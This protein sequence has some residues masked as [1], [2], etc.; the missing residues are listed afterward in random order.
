MADRL[1]LVEDKAEL[2]QMLRLALERAGFQVTEAADGTQ[3]TLLI[4][5]QPFSIVLTDLRLP[6]CSGLE[7][8]R[9]MQEADA[10]VPVVVMTAYGSIE[11]AVR[12]MK[13]GAYDF[14][15]KPVDLEHL[16]LL[17]QRALLQ[18]Q[19][20]RENLLLKEEVSTRYGFPRIIA[21]HPCMVA[22]GR[23]VQ[24]V[25]RAGVDRATAR[26]KRNGQ[27]AFCARHSSA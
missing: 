26:G 5:S 8:L 2:R 20:V 14:I 13:E 24:R 4:E 12:A 23:D 15:Q 16:R 18:Q 6:G 27:G 7:L 22:V 17:L 21:E 1:L 3:A 9:K 11:E 19:L 25:A 10:G